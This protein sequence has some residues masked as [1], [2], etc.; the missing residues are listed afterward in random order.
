M[1]TLLQSTVAILAMAAALAR[2]A[3]AGSAH[4][5]LGVSVRDVTQDLH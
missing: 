5:Y 4:G 1:K 3:A 2:P